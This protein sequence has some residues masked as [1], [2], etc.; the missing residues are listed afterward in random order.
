MYALLEIRGKQY[1]VKENSTILVPGWEEIKPEEVKV[2]MVKD[3]EN[4]VV[5]TPFVESAEIEFEPVKQIRTKKIK[6][7][8]FKAKVNYHR[9]K[10]HRI[11]YTILRVK[12]IKT[13]VLTEG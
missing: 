2:L 13:S 7:R 10:S 6:V 11:R 3:E 12:G 4:T 5:G 1:K 8:R 9:K